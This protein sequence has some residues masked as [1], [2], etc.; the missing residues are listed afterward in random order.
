[1][2]GKIRTLWTEFVN[3]LCRVRVVGLYI[4]VVAF[5]VGI[6]PCPWK[7]WLDIGRWDGLWRQTQLFHKCGILLQRGYQFRLGRGI[8]QGG[9]RKLG[10]GRFDCPDAISKP[11]HGSSNLVSLGSSS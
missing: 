9:R 8:E 6:V 3:D 4:D 5:D 2:C 1:M 11:I 7:Y 10:N